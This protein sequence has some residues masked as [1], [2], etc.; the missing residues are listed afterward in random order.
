MVTWQ[1]TRAVPVRGLAW[2]RWASLKGEGLSWQEPGALGD[3][4][5]LESFFLFR[6]VVFPA[7]RVQ[8][9]PHLQ[10]PRGVSSSLGSP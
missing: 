6:N 5:D 2:Q 7:F 10:L 9:F 3:S 8:A 4:K 1:E